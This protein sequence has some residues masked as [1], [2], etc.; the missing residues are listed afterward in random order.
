MKNKL[1]KLVTSTDQIRLNQIGGNIIVALAFAFCLWLLTNDRLQQ[2]FIAFI[3]LLVMGIVMTERAGW[4]KRV[5][6]LR[7]QI[8]SLAKATGTDLLADVPGPVLEALRQGNRAEA[9]KRYG[10]ATGTGYFETLGIIDDLIY[11][12]QNAQPIQP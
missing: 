2:Y 1:N 5:L 8:Q 10:E 12:L 6:C 11:Y 3:F 4:M 9:V 7:K